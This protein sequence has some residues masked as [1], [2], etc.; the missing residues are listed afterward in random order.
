MTGI[1]RPR[2]A[3]TALWYGFS[4]GPVTWAIHIVGDAALVQYACNATRWHWTL[5]ALTLATAIP[6]AIGLAICLSIARRIP[7]PEDAASPAG[8][9]DFLAKVGALTSAISLALILL[10]GSYVLFIRRC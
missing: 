6:T 8:R 5:H 3:M 1:A 4:V 9:T 7:D 10:E 2:P